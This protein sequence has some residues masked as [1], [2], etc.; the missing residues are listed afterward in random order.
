[1]GMAFQP[2][3]EHMY[4]KSGR[5]LF[6]FR[7]KTL[8]LIKTDKHTHERID[9]LAAAHA[10]LAGCARPF[11]AYLGHS[12]QITSSAEISKQ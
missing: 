5:V 11:V 3:V 10:A 9:R 4:M 2:P 1:M 7:I 6:E 8:I 12:A